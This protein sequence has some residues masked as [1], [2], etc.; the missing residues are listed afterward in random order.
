M[1]KK[2]GRPKLAKS[3]R[4]ASVIVVRVQPAERKVLLAAAKRAGNRLSDW[5]RTALMRSAGA[6]IMENTEAEGAGIQPQH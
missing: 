1:A 3:E 2:R 5:M 6:G 4:K